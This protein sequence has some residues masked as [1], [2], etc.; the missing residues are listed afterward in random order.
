MILTLKYPWDGDYAKDNPRQDGDSDKQI[1]LCDN[2]LGLPRLGNP[3]GIPGE[4]LGNHIDC[5]IYHKLHTL[6]N[7]FRY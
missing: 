3:W 4:P 6:L 7:A 1:F 2:L 5:C